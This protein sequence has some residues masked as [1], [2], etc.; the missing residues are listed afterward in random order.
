MAISYSIVPTP[1]G[2]AATGDA[3][4]SYV[5][6]HAD[7]LR[8]FA[9]VQSVAAVTFLTHTAWLAASARSGRSGELM[10]DLVFG[11]GLLVTAVSLISERQ[12]RRSHSAS[13]PTPTLQ[14][15]PACTTWPIWSST[16]ATS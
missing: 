14:S 6:D 16:S 1:P 5:V 8:W 15:P 3:V 4:A 2:T 12:R 9:L 13:P 11:A 10:H 7:G